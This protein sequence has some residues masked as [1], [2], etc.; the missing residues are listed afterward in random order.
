MAYQSYLVERFETTHENV[1]FRELNE[2]FLEEYGDKNG[3]HVFIGNLSVGG[4]KLDAIF[5]KSGAIIVLDFKDY[6]GDLTFSENGSWLIKNKGKTIFVSG[7]AV[8]RNPF[9]QVNAYRFSLFQYLADNESRILAQNQTTIK[10]DHTNCM[11]LFH[12]DINFDRNQIPAK[13]QRFF[14]ISTKNLIRSHINDNHSQRMLLTDQNIASILSVLS[15]GQHQQYDASQEL[16]EE[17]KNR[18]RYSP[19]NKIRIDQ[20]LPHKEDNYALNV[21]NYYSTM[22]GIE[23][24]NDV[25]ITNIVHIGIDWNQV[26]DGAFTLDLSLYSGFHADFQKNRMANFPKHLFVSINVDLNGTIIPLLFNTIMNTEIKNL[27]EIPIHFNLFDVFSSVLSELEVSENIINEITQ[28]VGEVATFKDKIAAVSKVLGITLVIQPYISLGLSNEAMYSAQLQSEIKTIIKQTQLGGALPPVLNTV[29]NVDAKL[30]PLLSN[31]EFKLL[32]ISSLNDSQRE[33]VSLSFKQPLTI[34]TGPPGTGKSQVVMNI[35]ANALYQNE[36]VLFASKNNKAVDNVYQRL[37]QVLDTDYFIRLGNAE[38]N[39]KTVDLLDKFSNIPVQADKEVLEAELE[40]AEQNYQQLLEKIAKVAGKLNQ[41]PEVAQ[42]VEKSKIELTAAKELYQS[43]VTGVHIGY[44]K[45]FIQDKERISIS[46]SALNLYINKLN[47][48]HGFIG[49]LLFNIFQKTKLLAAVTEL[50]KSQSKAIAQY[51]DQQS[52][53]FSEDKTIKESLLANL[54]YIKSLL[55]HQEQ[56]VA[57]ENSHLKTIAQLTDAYAI[58]DE[59]LKELKEEEPAL[60]ASLLLLSDEGVS[61]SKEL[62]GKKIAYNKASASISAIS[63][64]RGYLTTGI[65][66]KNEEQKV[67]S[68]TINNFL[69]HYKA[70]SVSNLAVKK[71]FLMEKELFDLL[72]IDEA[73][74]SDITSVLPMLYRAKRV[75][76][77]GDPLQLTHIT[78][79]SKD[80]NSYVA[81]KLGISIYDHNYVMDSLFLH[82]D[83]IAGKHEM[84]PVFLDEHYRCHPEIIQFSNQYFYKEMAG[85]EMTIRSTASQFTIGD[86]GFNWEDVQGK[87]DEHSNT[88]KAEI[89]KCLSLGLALRNKY[90][91]AS[92]GITT[93]FNHQK[94]QLIKAFAPYPELKIVVDTVHRFQGD[95]KDIMIFSLVCSEGARSSMTNFIN[96]YAKNLINVGVTRAKSALYIVGNK[97]YCSQLMDKNQKTLLAKLADYSKLLNK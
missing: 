33:A 6:A 37:N 22:L 32:T 66:W 89:E 51:I 96:H 34:I 35:M 30:P 62:I 60:R 68:Q 16:Q 70:V 10:W 63:S 91:D 41:L 31:R 40:T 64:Y 4:H 84:R 92:I 90:P 72:I 95:E 48:A 94:H 73:S 55:E 2:F 58:Q 20:I 14:H 19:I 3:N 18:M 76:I 82:A 50:N 17:N 86:R 21:L 28:V 53:Y 26:N 67:C 81:E 49:N 11:V 75:V 71:S 83:K 88:N 56:L 1:F 44:Y 52:P 5:I 54:K 38:E 65:P 61:L 80:E 85:Q 77:L 97:S 45:L 7:G 8:S 74:Q 46:N 9:Q 42:K 29:L 25:E 36:R 78:S 57:A 87:V 93:P 12:H 43:W 79:V 13:S 69:N 59:L 27:L 24:F 23:R 39:R 47:A 15:I